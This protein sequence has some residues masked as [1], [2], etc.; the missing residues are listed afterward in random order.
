MI[1]NNWYP[2]AFS[3]DIEDRPLAVRML[4]CEFVLFRTENGDAVCLSN[5]CCH[6]GGSLGHGRCI[7]SCVQC[8]YH[9][10]I[11]NADGNCTSIPPLG[12]T[13]KIRKQVRI[14]AYPTQEKYGL[15]WAFLGDMEESERPALADSLPE[16]GDTENWRM[17]SK[18][19]E[20]NC[21]WQRLME[22]LVDPSHAHFVHHFG[23]HLPEKTPIFPIEEGEWSGRINAVFEK[24]PTGDNRT[25]M[26]TPQAEKTRDHSVVITDFNLIGLLHKN[27]Q[28]KSSG[29]NQI[30]WDV[31]VPIDFYNTRQ[32]V[33]FFRGYLIEPENDEKIA[34]ALDWTF[35]EDEAILKHQQ[36]RLI[37]ADVTE[38]L[39]TPT[40]YPEMAWRRLAD[41]GRKQLGAVK[42]VPDQDQVRVIPSP[43]R[44]KEPENW[45]HK[46]V[47]LI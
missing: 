6:R 43:T 22:N 7:N 27:Y 39:M 28:E 44:R 3:K 29:Y 46:P 12:E 36:P 14:D 21:N 10:W 24:V 45:I 18:Q 4:G 13:A 5:V 37:P 32:F 35:K 15:I 33:L 30:V 40:D 38:E 34:K 31:S 19:Y 16:Y 25:V 42:Q 8:P 23:R 20:W 11:F 17:I 41:K 26:A 1:I 2:A 9:G 47:E